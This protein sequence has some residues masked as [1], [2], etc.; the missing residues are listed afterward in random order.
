MKA[1][2][3]EAIAIGKVAVIGAGAMGGG[4]AAQF[5]NAG[6]EVE[7]LDVAGGDNGTA[8]ADAGLARQLKI[9]GFMVPEAA[10]LVRT[11]NIDDHLARLRDV[12]WVVEVVVEKLAV[13]R[14][15]FER[16]QPFLKPDA[17]ISSNTSTIRRADLI[18]GMGDDFARRF[19][20][21]HFFNPPRLM[22]LLEIVADPDAAPAFVEK[23]HQA[24]KVLLGKTVI[25]CHDT[26][27]FIANRIG[28]FWLAVSVMEAM[29]LGL[30]IETADAVQTALGVPKT[31]AFGL[32]DLIGIDLVPTIWGSLMQSL[33]TSD[34]MHLYDLP[35]QPVISHLLANGSLGRKAGAGFYRKSTNGSF[36]VLD[37][38]NFEYRAKN[39]SQ[40]N[41]YTLESVTADQGVIGD[42]ARNVLSAVIA[43]SA[44]HLPEIARD[45]G[46]IDQA[47]QL[48]YSW[49]K[50]PFALADALAD[51]H[52]LIA[53]AQDCAILR[54]GV[55]QGFYLEGKALRAD[56]SRAPQIMAELVA[57]KPLLMGNSAA[58][59][60]D[61]GDGVACFR[62]HTKMNVMSVEVFDLLEQVLAGAGSHYSALILANDDAR[63][64]SAGADLAHFARLMQ[65]PDSK[66][67]IEA[68]VGR[69]QRL[70]LQMLHLPVPVVAAV[71]GFALG[72]GC[73]FQMHA[74]VTIAHAEANIGLPETGVGLVP[75][76]GGCT[77]LLAR[78]A[79]QCADDES[80]VDRVFATISQGQVCNSAAEAKKHG[81]LRESDQIV[82]HRSLLLPAAKAQ[83]LKMLPDYVAAKPAKLIEPGPK[84]G[85]GSLAQSA[86]R[87]QQGLIS[88]ADHQIEQCLLQVLCGAS[89][90]AGRSEQSL[91]QSELDALLA[92][93]LTPTTQQRIDHMLKTGKRLRN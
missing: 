34:A 83:A 57:Q 8:A 80:I 79:Q 58:S 29:R 5:A 4:I 7:L 88:A 17:I 66:A 67:V 19:A 2:G 10:R 50:G 76:W 60:H 48:G 30:D 21:S 93:A 87:L 71:Q 54:N 18:A 78:H 61:L 53:A 86:S 40:V 74:D 84:A 46:A 62:V 64:F 68:Y 14:A 26:P 11:G 47:M 36:E 42:Y 82:M 41:D 89:V 37:L 65:Q 91:M 16:I 92:L 3:A 35:G 52:F 49:R 12:D 22:P 55:Q 43:Y 63:A 13:K 38:Q 28:C 25:D 45:A 59:L 56:G 77:Q 70:F 27:G 31:G 72:G 20:I 33:P 24:A 15:L 73:E 90:G 1:L 44:L 32:L 51:N 75:G 85:A 23:L 69:G 81:L 6:I 9:G 39:A